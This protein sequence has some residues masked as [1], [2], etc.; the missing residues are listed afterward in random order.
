MIFILIPLAHIKPN[1]HYYGQGQGHQSLAMHH[2]HADPIFYNPTVTDSMMSST[3]A[4]MFILG[5]QNAPNEYL[6]LLYRNYSLDVIDVIIC[7]HMI[8]KHK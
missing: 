6:D 3:T 4:G 1:P 8:H 2:D 7:E 5:G